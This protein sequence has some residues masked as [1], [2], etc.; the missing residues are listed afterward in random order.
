MYAIVLCCDSHHKFAYHTILTYQNLWKSNNFVFRVPWN[1]VYP[2]YLK[3]KFGN[4]IELIKT[5]VEF[6]KT[7]EKLIEDIDDEEWVYWCESDLYLEYI[8][9]N[10]ANLVYN[11]VK[12]QSYKNV[13]GVTGSV[14]QLIL[15]KKMRAFDDNSKTIIF[16]GLNFKERS[17]WSNPNNISIWFHQYFRKKLLYKIFLYFKEPNIAKGFDY[18]INNNCGLIKDNIWDNSIMYCL[19]HD[20]YIL[21]E[22]SS[23]GKILKN[24]CKS[25]K[26][27]GLEI[28]KSFEITDKVQYWSKYYPN[29]NLESE[30][31]FLEER[32]VYINNVLL[33]SFCDMK[34]I[35]DIEESS[36]FS[37]I[38]KIYVISL[39]HRK[40]RRYELLNEFKKVGIISNVRF[41]YAETYKNIYDS[42]Y[43]YNL[44]EI[45]DIE[46]K[47]FKQ[48]KIIKKQHGH[49]G[50]FVS[51]L[52]CYKDAK[53]N[54]Y[55]NIL[56]LEDDC[57][58]Y[59]GINKILNKIDFNIIKELYDICYFG[60]YSKN[61]IKIKKTNINY[62]YEVIEHKFI[63]MT[64][65]ILAN[66][67]LIDII[68]KIKIPEKM[69]TKR[70]GIDDLL[71]EL[72]FSKI[73]PYIIYPNI[74]YQRLSYSDN[75]LRI[76]KRELITEPTIV[77]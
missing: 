77:D 49:F 31:D 34:E 70:W 25:F 35:K 62:F 73:K 52:L 26:K 66:E 36:F 51:Q 46:D 64:H 27:Y 69:Y 28:P 60:Y 21:G 61:K 32:K 39:R 75:D 67:K 43:H 2:E 33:G 16:S 38:D 71:Y 15:R 53:K 23:R 47:K 24:C 7:I 3:E 20:I 55:K 63:G 54:N 44:N 65:S 72:F 41:F 56:I 17:K 5:P 59:K 19:D 40:D 14:P 12:E 76:D 9:E 8:N 57:S 4:K 37:K 1:D 29:P 42:G 22:S 58:F 6:K 45:F 18:Q 48:L 30:I 50:C 11:F 68:S 10:K 74:T 13:I